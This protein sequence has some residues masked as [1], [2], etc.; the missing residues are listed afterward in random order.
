MPSTVVGSAA[1]PE[2]SS[3]GQ[4]SDDEVGAALGLESDALAA[5]VEDVDGALLVDPLVD[6]VLPEDVLARLS[7]R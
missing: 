7:V 1:Q 2:R 4:E 6:A 5:G 3:T